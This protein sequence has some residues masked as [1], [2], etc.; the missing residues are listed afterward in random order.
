MFFNQHTKPKNTQKTGA[1]QVPDAVTPDK[2]TEVKLPAKQQP[3][4]VNGKTV[5]HYDFYSYMLL[6]VSILKTDQK[7]SL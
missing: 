3:K 6:V 1:K 2:V 4:T 5:N 7:N